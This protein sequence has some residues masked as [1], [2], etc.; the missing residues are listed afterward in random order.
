MRPASL[1][2]IVRRHFVYC[3]NVRGMAVHDVINR[4]GIS[5]GELCRLI[6]DQTGPR[7]PLR[8]YFHIARWLQMPLANVSALAGLKPGLP[9]LMQFGMEIQGHRPSSVADQ[10]TAADQVG[11]GVAVFR[12]ALHGYM[13]F[14]PSL[15][16]CRAIASWLAWT[17]FTV[18]DI[19]QAAGMTIRALPSGRQL[20]LSLDISQRIDPYP[21]ACGRVGCMV[22]AHIPAGPRR[23]W[24]SDACRMWARRQ[25]RAAG[26]LPHSSPIVRF[27]MINE[28][29][30]P[31]RF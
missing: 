31:V 11:I 3:I 25:R 28:R 30:V 15:R 19:A 27:I 23:Q 29:Q 17:G 12:R 9:E 24:R 1:S 14:K 16:T 20:T 13:D 4:V 22:P 26:T 7:L 10:M 8:V 21:C 18:D 6:A 2:M 5:P